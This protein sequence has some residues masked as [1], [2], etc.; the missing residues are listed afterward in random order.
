MNKT[1]FYIDHNLSFGLVIPQDSLTN[2]M[3]KFGK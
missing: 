1:V 3:I 2:K